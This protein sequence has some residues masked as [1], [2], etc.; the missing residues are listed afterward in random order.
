MSAA[1]WNLALPVCPRENFIGRAT[2]CGAARNLPYI[3]SA[4]CRR[5]QA[6]SPRRAL[7]RNVAAAEDSGSYNAV[8]VFGKNANLG[9]STESRST[10]SSSRNFTCRADVLAADEKKRRRK[11][12]PY[13]SW[14]PMGRV[15]VAIKERLCPWL[16]MVS[17]KAADCRPSTSTESRCHLTLPE[18]RCR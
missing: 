6:R 2:L 14:Q 11:S 15:A 16:A 5:M 17:A 1:R 13:N 7:A 18:H 4:S 10:D 9:G 8:S 3:S 12:P